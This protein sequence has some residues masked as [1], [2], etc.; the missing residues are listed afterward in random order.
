MS[1][2]LARYGRRGTSVAVWGRGHLVT[3]VWYVVG[4]RHVRSWP[5]T[6][7]NRVYAKAW[8]QEFARQREQ[9]ERRVPL[10][11]AEL[12]AR[13]TEHE[14]EHLRPR[15]RALYAE[16]WRRWA[17]LVAPES[18][19]EDLGMADMA[20]LVRA[21][22]DRAPATIRETLATVKRVYRWGQRHRL[23]DRNEI[24][25]YRYQASKA[26]RRPSPGE[27]R[28]EEFEALLAQLDPTSRGQWRAHGVIALCGY[29]GARVNAV[30]HLRWEDID[31]DAGTVT[32]R[33]AWDKLGI[34]RVQPLRVPSQRVLVGL[35]AWT[36]GEGWLF[37]P[38]N[39]QGRGEVYTVRGVWV[40]LTAAEQR[41]GVP[42]RDRRALHGLRRMLFNDV[43]DATGDLAA[44]MEA[45]GDRDL[46]VASRY[47]QDRQDRV[48]AAF[49]ALDGEGAA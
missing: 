49:D 41:A 9:G 13:Y 40:A 42:H 29:Q 19:A 14:W 1:Q 6:P 3:A 17:V 24:R 12:W 27:Y 30:L 46:K 48:R 33:A 32:W 20:R 43:Q 23:L 10:T 28:R 39:S 18:I 26:A 38:G 37:P 5:N 31:L 47:R 7:A 21:M 45:I 11:T 25:D 22:R 15:S 2:P 16:Y 35:R 4:I 44:A 8:A 34:E 36:D